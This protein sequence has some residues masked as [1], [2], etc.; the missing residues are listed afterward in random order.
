MRMATKKSFAD[1][2]TEQTLEELAGDRSFEHGRDY[3]HRGA[4][5]RLRVDASR[6]T[7][8]VAGSETYTTKLWIDEGELG[9]DCSCPIGEEGEFCKH[10]VATALAW[11]NH[12]S[13]A[14]GD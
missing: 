3:L 12:A 13:D 1:L 8:R 14:R 6:I 5:V 7:A 4:V 10:L 9:Y 2:I 11:L